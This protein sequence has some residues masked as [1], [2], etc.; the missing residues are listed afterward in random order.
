LTDTTDLQHDGADAPAAQ[1]DPPPLRAPAAGTSGG[2]AAM[3][4]PEL[5]A[6]PARSAS[7]ASPAC[8]RAS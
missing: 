8:A 6:S 1:A 2:L 3:V 4:L 5:Q 7:P